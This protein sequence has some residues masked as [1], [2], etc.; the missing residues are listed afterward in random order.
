VGPG[1]LCG[2]D[3]DNDGWSDV[4]LSC[5]EATCTQDNCVGTPNSGQEDADGDGQGDACDNDSDN[6]GYDDTRDNCPTVPNSNQADSDGDGVGDACDNCVYV[7]NKHQ[8]NCDDDAFGDACDTDIDNDGITNYYDNC[9]SVANPLQTDSDSDTVGDACD[10]CPNDY[11]PTQLDENG[12][13]LGDACD[14]GIDTDRDGIP[15]SGDNCATTRNADQLDSDLDGDG[16]VCDTDKDNDGVGDSTDNC[17]IVA[18]PGQEDRDGD[19]TGDVCQDDCDGDGNPDDTDVCPC[20]NF[21]A[22]TDFR[23]IQNFSLGQNSYNQ[24]QPVWEFRD[25]G[26]EIL[27]KIN[28]APG[29][30]I[31]V[32]RLGGVEFEGTIFVNTYTD[33]DWIGSIFSFQDTSNFYLFMGSKAGSGQGSWQIKRINSVTGP[34]LTSISAAVQKDY[35]VSGQ[36]T[37]L[38]KSGTTRQI[39]KK[40]TNS[41]VD[42]L[43]PELNRGARASSIEGWNSKTSYRFTIIH[44]P[45]QGL[46]RLKLYEGS[47]LVVDS[48]NIIDTGADRLSGGKL[49]VYCDSQQDISWSAL[50]YRCLS[51]TFSP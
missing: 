30:A 9:E 24:P 13:G 49:G 3:N 16:D 39:N 41:S 45:E 25:D 50:R 4:S 6:D 29:I 32:A 21:I 27:Q 2:P 47:T 44:L 22:A 40:N 42:D 14:D 17:P 36:T 20:N 10:S 38:W 26:R 48:G 43:G 37:V 15:D 23:G 7:S 11:N 46:I 34:V 33:D 18:N 19:G 1:Y 28:S 51:D 12:N 5:N 35:S 8:E 31:G